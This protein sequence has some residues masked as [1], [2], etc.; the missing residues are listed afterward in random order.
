M[1]KVSR[2]STVKSKVEVS[3]V[4]PAAEGLV[5]GDL[6]TQVAMIQA[7]IPLGLEAVHDELQNEMIQLAGPRY[8]RKGAHQPCRR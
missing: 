1:G 5:D 8:G 7:L 4:H 2:K 6:D 3:P